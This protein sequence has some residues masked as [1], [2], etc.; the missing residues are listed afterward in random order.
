AGGFGAIGVVL[1]TRDRASLSEVENAGI[2]RVVIAMALLV[3][4][5][6]TDF[7]S[8]WPDVPLRFGAVG[9]LVVLFFA[10]GPGRST[11]RE[12]IVSLVVFAAIAALFAFGSGPAG[13]GGAPERG[14]RATAVGLCG[15]IFAG[16]SS[17]ALG[18][19]SERRR[20]AAPLLA[21]ST[22][23]QFAAAL[24]DHRL[25]SNAVILDAAD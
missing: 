7:R 11:D 22:C 4:L 3:P 20:P 23:E 12:R 21:A 15:L 5:I 2:R 18:A 8:I 24:K 13:R 17:E 25:I 14:F 9:A 6:A 10:F 16:L 1:W 19:R